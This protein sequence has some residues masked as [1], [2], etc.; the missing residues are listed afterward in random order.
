MKKVT[1]VKKPNTF[2]TR[3][4]EEYI[5]WWGFWL[6]RIPPVVSVRIQPPVKDRCRALTL[7]LRSRYRYQ[8]LVRSCNFNH[9][10]TRSWRFSIPPNT[11]SKGIMS[12]DPL[13]KYSP[14]TTFIPRLL[15]LLQ[16]HQFQPHKLYTASY[17]PQRCR[18]RN[19]SLFLVEAAQPITLLTSSRTSARIVKEPLISFSL[20]PIME[21]VPLRS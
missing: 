18:R 10:A 4:S 2:L 16:Y 1:A 13:P 3:I 11:R 5:F 8:T 6:L 14:R 17:T 20:F 9:I 15:H 21:E 7:G 12:P 19:T